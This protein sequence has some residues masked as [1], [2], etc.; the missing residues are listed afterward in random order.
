MRMPSILAWPPI[1]L[2]A[3]RKAA[4]QRPSKAAQKADGILAAQTGR[5]PPPR[6]DFEDDEPPGDQ[7]DITV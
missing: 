7:F 3:L 4:T 6:Y 5:V 2:P 1:A